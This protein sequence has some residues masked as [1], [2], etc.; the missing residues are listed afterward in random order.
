M[1]MDQCCRAPPGGEHHEV[2]NHTASFAPGGNRCY[3]VWLGS[4]AKKHTSRISPGSTFIMCC[5]TEIFNRVDPVSRASGLA[6]RLGNKTHIQDCPRGRS[7]LC[8]LGTSIFSK[9][10]IV[11][12][13]SLKRA[14]RKWRSAFAERGCAWPVCLLRNAA[15]IPG[16]ECIFT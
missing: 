2:D 4:W 15:L 12:Y 6:R 5:S 11:E 10:P 7:S 8:G 1:V 13:P 16:R 14:E 3:V 9:L